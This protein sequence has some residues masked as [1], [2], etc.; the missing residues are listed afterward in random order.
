MQE[1]VVTPDISSILSQ[2]F[3][4]R[5]K[6]QLSLKIGKYSNGSI[7]N[8][9][10]EY[11]NYMIEGEFKSFFRNG[12]LKEHFFKK[13]GADI[14]EYKSYHSNGNLKEQYHVTP[15]NGRHGEY[16]RF[17]KNK[18]LLEHCFYKDDEYHGKYISYYYLYIFN[19]LIY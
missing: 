13:N 10:F 7:R 6:K 9:Y 1:T 3:S 19:F 2:K 4:K 15:W 8:A 12:N 14:G 11:H 18:Q 16:K 17:A 5:I